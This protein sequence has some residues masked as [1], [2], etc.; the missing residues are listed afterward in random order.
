[1]KRLQALR[2]WVTTW[3]GDFGGKFYLALA[4][5]LVGSLAFLAGKVSEEIRP[6]EPLVISVPSEI[7]EARP[8]EKQINSVAPSSENALP[9]KAPNAVSPSQCAYV[10]SRKSNKYHLPTSRC[11]KQIKEENRICFVDLAAAE[12][13]GYLPGCLS[14]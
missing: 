5:L 9:A 11:A 8:V 12:K 14:Q 13:K 4:F 10:G 2:E 1:M 3:W 7:P 6:V